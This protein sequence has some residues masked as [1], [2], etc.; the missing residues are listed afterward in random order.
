ML[1]GLYLAPSTFLPSLHNTCL[2]PPHRAVHCIPV[3]GV[4][5]TGRCGE[6][7]SGLNRCHLPSLPKRLIKLSSD[8]RPDGRLPAFAWD[9]IE[10]SPTTSPEGSIPIHP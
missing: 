8:E 10:V 5:S 3:D 4:P 7:T 9:D 2:E 1:Q 6:C